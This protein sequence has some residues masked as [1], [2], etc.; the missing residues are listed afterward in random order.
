MAILLII[1]KQTLVK[2]CSLAILDDKLGSDRVS[3]LF[4]ET[5]ELSV[6]QKKIKLELNG[7]IC[8]HNLKIV[9]FPY[10]S[11][12]SPIMLVPYIIV[13]SVY[14]KEFMETILCASY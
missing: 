8:V 11:S 2:F 7:R 1:Q 10:I 6:L 12:M 4:S 14:V 5:S 13:H 3:Q 9:G